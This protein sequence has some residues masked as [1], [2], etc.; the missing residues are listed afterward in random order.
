V[1]K[2]F[3][4]EEE[5]APL[6]KQ[7]KKEDIYRK[8]YKEVFPKERYAP[9]KMKKCSDDWI[10]KKIGKGEKLTIAEAKLRTM[11]RHVEINRLQPRYKRYLSRNGNSILLKLE[12][13]NQIKNSQHY[14][15]TLG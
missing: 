13:K 3:P 5:L 7:H 2:S 14:G 12:K 6:F 15:R 4:K 11:R 10:D 1:Q 8:H 9:T